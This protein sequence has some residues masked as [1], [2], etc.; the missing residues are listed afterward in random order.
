MN[1]EIVLRRQFDMDGVRKLTSPI[2]EEKERKGRR[3]NEREEER[4]EKRK[5]KTPAGKLK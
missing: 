2:L 4:E 5:R 1:V 3:E